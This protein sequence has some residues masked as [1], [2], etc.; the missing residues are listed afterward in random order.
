MKRTLLA[1]VLSLTLVPAAA[2]ADA[3]PRRPVLDAR[4]TAPP[5]KKSE[6]LIAK[7]G[8][9]LGGD[10]TRKSWKKLMAAGEAGCK[11]V[12]DWLGA[13]GAGEE[14]A[15]HR[16]V[17]EALIVSGDDAQLAIGM[18]WLQGHDTDTTLQ[19]VK[20]AEK[21]LVALTPEQSTFLASH[22]DK[23]V[24]DGSL[25][26]LIGYHSEGAIVPKKYGP[27]TVLEYV[28]TLWV[29][30][31]ES[32][33]EHHIAAVRSILE[34]GDHG[35]KQRVAKLGSRFY[36][37]RMSDQDVWADLTIDMVGVPK[38][39]EAQG[40][41]NVAA[42]LTAQGEGPRLGEMVDKI[43]AADNGETLEHLLDGLENGFKAGIATTATLGHLEKVAAG[44]AGKQ[45]KRA[46]RIHKKAAKKIK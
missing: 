21:R 41:A 45:H 35:T 34:Q 33:A 23:K 26:V 40:A 18:Q 42:R 30:S 5:S 10:D 14:L 3:T 9:G 13:G 17:A 39:D 2:M 32:P 12:S 29:G 1:A 7:F 19:I 8:E 6:K 27:V 28:E 31:P 24:R 38:G 4:C 20:A 11:L 36:K 37:E 43:L 16:D 46:A 25:G 15:G 44:G 22:E